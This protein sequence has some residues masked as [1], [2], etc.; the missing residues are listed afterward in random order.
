MRPIGLAL[1]YF[2]MAQFEIIDRIE[3]GPIDVD[4]EKVYFFIRQRLSVYFKHE[5]IHMNSS[6]VFV[7]GNLQSFSEH[8]ITHA[9]VHVKIEKGYLVYRVNGSVS[10]GGWPWIL[11]FL[12]FFT[13]I[14]MLVFFFLVFFYFQSKSNPERYF[15]DVFESIRFEFQ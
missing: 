8:A 12:G 9:S 10:F 6:G 4:I 2:D 14:F 15:R 3:I 7:N 1:G 11:F 5:N 13:G